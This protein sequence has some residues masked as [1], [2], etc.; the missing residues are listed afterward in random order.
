MLK[1]ILQSIRVKVEQLLGLDKGD[2]SY[3]VKEYLEK[4]K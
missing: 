4:G 2:L 1:S 3:L